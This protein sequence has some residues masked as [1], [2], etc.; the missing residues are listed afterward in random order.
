MGNENKVEAPGGD[1]LLALQNRINDLEAK[2]QAAE[3]A[4]A[5]KSWVDMATFD[6]K[7]ATLRAELRE[8]RK[9]KKEIVAVT[10]E[11]K[12]DV[13]TPQG[14]FWDNLKPLSLNPDE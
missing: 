5:G 13:K 4:Q 6:D 2:L 12:L 7:L 8:A 11:V 14:G 9:E 1:L 10:P 3:K